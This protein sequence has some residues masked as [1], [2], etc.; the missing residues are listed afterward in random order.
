MTAWK[1]AAIKPSAEN[2]IMILENDPLIRGRFG[3]DD[4]SHRILLKGDLPWHKKSEGIIWRD[5]DDA[6][7]RNYLSRYYKL[8]GRASSTTP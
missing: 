6:S 4:F 1:N 2:F 8:T 7:L 5:A 3:L